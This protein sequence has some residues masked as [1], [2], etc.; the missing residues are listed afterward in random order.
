MTPDQ[1]AEIMIEASQTKLVRHEFG[2]WEISPK[3]SKEELRKYYA[4]KYY[5]EPLGQYASSY[6]DE[7]IRYFRLKAQ[8][9]A[10]ILGRHGLTCGSMLEIGCG[11]GWGLQ[12]YADAGW[13]VTGIDYSDYAVKRFN[14]GV[15]DRVIKADFI[16]FLDGST[17]RFDFIIAQ[18]VLEHVPDPTATARALHGVLN[19]QSICVIN[20]PNDFSAL[21]KELLD[22]NF[23]DREFWVAPP[24]HLNYFSHESLQNLMLHCG[25]ACLLSVGGYPID[26]DLFT[27]HTNYVLNPTV[28][29][30]SHLR[31]VRVENFMA[32]QS[33]SAKVQYGEAL[34]ALGMGRDVIG[35]FR[36]LR[37]E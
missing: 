24:D 14:P 4:D 23:I 32:Q 35:Y 30:A 36:N 1:S 12:Y 16:E 22:K 2:Y 10:F 15:A 28:G 6:S 9:H 37:G 19:A 31:R 33:L 3:P 17:E 21:Q 13:Q 18:N 5:Q 20:V 34:A 29:G 26:L 7:E 8:E 25:F 11:E 27:E